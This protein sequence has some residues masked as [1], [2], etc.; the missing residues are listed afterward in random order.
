MSKQ[1]LNVLSVNISAKRGSKFPVGDIVL[2]SSGIDGDA[3]NGSSRPVSFII[4][5]EMSSDKFLEKD[6]NSEF[7]ENISLGCNTEIEIKEFDRFIS[8]DVEFEVIKTGRQ[9]NI[10]SG[11]PIKYA[12]SGVEFFCRVLSTGVLKRNDSL[13]FTPKVFRI[14]IIT[15]S[16]RASRGEYEDLSGPAVKSHVENI[17]SKNN[18]RFDVDVTVIP[19]D[20]DLLKEIILAE[21]HKADVIITT[22][23]TGIGPKD[24]T[25][26]VVKPLLDKEIP[27]IMEMIRIKYGMEKPNAY[28]S[29]GVAGITGKSLIYTLPGS[30]KAVNEYMTEI[31][32]T[33]DHLFFMQYGIDIH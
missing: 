19:D 13:E 20:K 17:F 28:L 21:K 7:L 14:K 15:L 9:K 16:D 29:R 8:G 22:G 11:E 26:D 1:T 31:G 32:K 30:V 4:Y 12:S 33:L 27:G 25:V 2:N 24:F 6:D 5:P 10:E 3:D 23:G 18:R